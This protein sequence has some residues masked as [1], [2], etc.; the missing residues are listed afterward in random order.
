MTITL[1]ETNGVTKVTFEVTGIPA[2]VPVEGATMAYSQQ[3]DL[4]TLLVEAAW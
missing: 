3:L 4:F 2:M 1:V